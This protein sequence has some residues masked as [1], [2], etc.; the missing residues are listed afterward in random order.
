MNKLNLSGKLSLKK[1]TIAKLSSTQ[2]ADIQG[3]TSGHSCFGT[4]YP[5][6]TCNP[7]G[8]ETC[9]C[10]ITLCSCNASCAC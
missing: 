10:T 4:C 6:A 7:P 5:Q 8:A 3:G 9:D 2:M 1:E